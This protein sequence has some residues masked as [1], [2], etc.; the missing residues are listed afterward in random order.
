MNNSNTILNKELNLATSNVFP[1][2]KLKTRNN[3]LSRK[4]LH[5]AVISRQ[6]MPVQA[7]PLL[8]KERY[9]KSGMEEQVITAE[10][11]W[12]SGMEVRDLELSNPYPFDITLRD[13]C[14]IPISPN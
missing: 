2:R 3:V 7:L 9:W 13:T 8:Q 1:L 5:S 12:K 10:T 11:V 6:K 4:N 14:I